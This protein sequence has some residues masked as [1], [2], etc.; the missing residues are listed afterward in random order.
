MKKVVTN[1]T[2]WIFAIG[3]LG[4]SIL[5]GIVSNWFV[6]FYAPADAKIEA[7]HTLFIPQGIIFLGLTVL[8]L[9]AASGRIFDAI[10]DPWI[11]GKSDGC[12]HK[13]GKRI[14]FMRYS[15]LPFALVT[16][17]LFVSPIDHI[18]SINIIPL[19]IFSILFYLFMT[20]YC[21]PYN[22]LIPVLGN[23]QKNRI[24][25]TTFMSLTFI[26]G[27]TIATA[28]PNIAGIFTEQLGYIN[29][30]RL[31]VAILACIALICMLIPSFVIKEKEYDDSEPASTG[32]I[33]SLGKTFKNKQFRT[34]VISDIL[35]WI[36]LTIFQTGLPYYITS[37]MG[38]KEDQTF[39]FTVIMTATSLLFYPVVN[40]V[41]KRIGKKKMVV[42]AFCFFSGTFLF[43]SFS[44]QLGIPGMA[45]G[46]IVALAA[47]IPMSILGILP[48]AIV[49]DIS[50]SETITTKENREGM[51]F[52]ARTFAFKLGQAGA[53]VIFTSV[54]LIGSPSF[55]LRLTA[56]IAFVFCLLGAIVLAKYN[57]KSIYKSIGVKYGKQD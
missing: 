25:V 6:F 5:S 1:K 48:P 23:T 46:I 37:L 41:S 42:F 18:S 21:T 51:F 57:E 33:K 29:S 3:Q 38:L 16:V 26:M 19:A 17:L 34:F 53:M 56:I 30:F 10:T 45:N 35:Y 11:A 43:T 31:A 20:I 44:G 49:A 9:I 47:A 36:S 28:L 22:A 50:E 55:G 13:L 32:T 12:K 52:A 4:W 7:G 39:I 40:T 54:K 14:P 2:L 24:N 15:A 8:G 27:T